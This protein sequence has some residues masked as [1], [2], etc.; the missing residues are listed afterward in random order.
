L[1]AEKDKKD[2]EK[3]VERLQQKL[4]KSK[5]PVSLISN[6]G[7]KKILSLEGDI[8]VTVNEDKMEKATLFKTVKVGI[9]TRTTKSV[10]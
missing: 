7:Y 9:N 1:Q 2:R 4:S 5:N 3:A 6:Y 10:E 8:T